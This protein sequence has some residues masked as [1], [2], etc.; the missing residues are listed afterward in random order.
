MK[1]V[2]TL[3]RW[4]APPL[5]GLLG[6]L[7]SAQA[8]GDSAEATA[9]APPTMGSV[10]A[11]TSPADWRALDPQNSLVM[12]LADGDLIIELAPQFA[13]LHVANIRTLVRD[14]YFDQSAVL[15]VQENYVVQWGSP[16]EQRP[17]G[18]A[19][20][21]L[22]METVRPADGE[23]MDAL[24]PDGDV[25][26]AQVGYRDGFPVALDADGKQAW[27]A[28]C[29][30]MVGVGRGMEADSGNGSSLY[31]VTGH[32][33]RHLD[34]NI[35]LVGRVRSGMEHLTT[36]PRG[37]GPLGFYERPEQQVPVLSIRLLASLPKAARPALQ[38]MRTDTTSFEQLI[39]ARRHRHE[40]WFLDPVGRLELCNMPVPV[41]TAAE[42]GA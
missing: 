42:P 20:A 35:T 6:L 13:P 18:D 27:L 34:R 32:A 22:P 30:G 33:P 2:Q 15:R 10:L 31:V 37:S 38:V 41:R 17:L 21:R 28:H 1:P 14:G 29:Y 11:A 23:F 5:A 9:A 7:G 24:L 40:A 12:A 8:L 36:L 39:Q 16:D 26:A 25:Y 4:A 3:M 19:Q